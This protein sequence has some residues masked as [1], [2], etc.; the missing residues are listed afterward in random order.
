MNNRRKL[1]V[2]LGAGALTAPFASI[3]Q[4]Q[5]KIWRIGYLASQSASSE[6]DRLEDMRAGLRDLGYLENKNRVF[7]ESSG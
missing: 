3:A 1:V 4:Q 6:L 7:T 5:G 2:A